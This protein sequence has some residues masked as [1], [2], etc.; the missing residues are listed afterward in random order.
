[1][2]ITIIAIIV[3]VMRKNH[4][5]HK[6]GTPIV[7]K[8]AIII[9][10]NLIVFDLKSQNTMLIVKR[11]NDSV[12]NHYIDTEFSQKCK[13]GLK[14]KRSAK[15]E[16]KDQQCLATFFDIWRFLSMDKANNDNQILYNYVVNK[17]Y[18]YVSAN[19]YDG[20]AV[21]T[22]GGG[23]YYLEFGIDTKERK[24]IGGLGDNLNNIFCNNYSFMDYP[25]IRDFI[26]K[27]FPF[28]INVVDQD[29]CLFSGFY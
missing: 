16:K 6:I 19:I 26:M 10:I 20:E 8:L 2:I 17:K 18:K 9:S 29:V 1:M 22:I 27:D 11:H 7:I 4:L 5:V 28:K 3:I 14:I 24:I 21:I 12:I 15:R 13:E 25:Y 23:N